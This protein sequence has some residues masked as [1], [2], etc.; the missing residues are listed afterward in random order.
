[1]R[2]EGDEPGEAGAGHLPPRRLVPANG[3][4]DPEG[5]PATFNL[6]AP[7]A[8]RG[9]GSSTR[10]G[11]YGGSRFNCSNPVTGG[12]MISEGGGRGAVFLPGGGMVMTPNRRGPVADESLRPPDAGEF[13]R[14]LHF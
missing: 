11:D 9:G 12:G 4:G 1:M 6:A 10:C 3:I 7:C 5:G 2:H 14:D 13:A 8:P